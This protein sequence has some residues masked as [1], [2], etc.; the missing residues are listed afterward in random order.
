MLTMSMPSTKVAPLMF[1]I[2]RVVTV[3]TGAVA[4]VV[5]VVVDVVVEVV[6]AGGAIKGLLRTVTFMS[7]LTAGFALLITET[8][9]VP[10][11]RFE[12]FTCFACRI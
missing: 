11:V 2:S 4:V 7:A 12:I 8:V 5:V 3:G 1:C 6:V 10:F 9:Q